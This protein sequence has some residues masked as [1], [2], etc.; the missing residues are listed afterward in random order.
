MATD[1]V[2]FLK[3]WRGY[4]ADEKAGFEA[5]TAAVLVD[6]GLAEYSGKSASKKKAS[7]TRTSK[8]PDATSTLATSATSTTAP[9]NPD[10]DDEKP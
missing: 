9:D 10:D 6:K 1:I 3:P 2:R 4:A 5:D 8:E 7:K